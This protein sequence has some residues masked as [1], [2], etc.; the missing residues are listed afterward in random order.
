MLQIT[1]VIPLMGTPP[2]CNSQ[3]SP[4]DVI[5]FYL[6][7]FVD[8]TLFFFFFFF[9]H[10]LEFKSRISKGGVFKYRI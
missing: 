7:W 9:S 6:I 8:I 5:L 1:R 3:L 4:S 10:L 2:L